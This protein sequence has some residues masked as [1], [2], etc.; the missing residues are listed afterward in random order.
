MS[1][2]GMVECTLSTLLLSLETLWRLVRF[3]K[4]HEYQ[5]NLAYDDCAGKCMQTPGLLLLF[6]FLTSLAASILTCLVHRLIITDSF[7]ERGSIAYLRTFVRL[8]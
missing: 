4:L 2:A 7:K 1:T 6:D 3:R 5:I 8:S